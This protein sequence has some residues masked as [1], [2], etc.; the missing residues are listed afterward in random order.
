MD[1]SAVP[2]FKKTFYLVKFLD[3]IAESGM[4]AFENAAMDFGWFPNMM[5]IT[6]VVMIYKEVWLLFFF[7][8]FFFFL[9]V[10]S[11]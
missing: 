1:R 8:F 2:V 3:T 7:F 6:A 9:S 5:V 11:F 10:S 4:R